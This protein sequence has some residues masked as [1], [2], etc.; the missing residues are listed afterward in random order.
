LTKVV[1]GKTKPSCSREG[2]GTD[3]LSETSKIIKQ[4]RLIYQ[5]GPAADAVL[6]YKAKWK[7]QGIGQ[8]G[9]L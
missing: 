6:K 5:T 9:L 1:R 7:N 8:S 3:V 4:P 2:I